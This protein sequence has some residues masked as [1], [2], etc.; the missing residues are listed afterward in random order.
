M[1]SSALWDKLR[2]ASP[3][4]VMSGPN[5]LQSEQHAMA[6]ACGLQAWRALSDS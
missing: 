2:N 6:I 3:F 5:V 4:F 1:R